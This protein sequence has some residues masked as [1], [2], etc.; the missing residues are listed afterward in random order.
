MQ[1]CALIVC[2]REERRLTLPS[3]QG[4]Q[5]S[6][7]VSPETESSKGETC[8]AWGHLH[9]SSERL[10]GKWLWLGPLVSFVPRQLS[11]LNCSLIGTSFAT[12]CEAGR[13]SL[14]SVT[15]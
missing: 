3:T 9:Y 10:G 5:N 1:R 14:F 15:C 6:S 7:V 12:I 8:R 2:L 13:I 4:K 11:S